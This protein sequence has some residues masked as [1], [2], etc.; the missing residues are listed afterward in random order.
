MIDEL[1]H[2]SFVTDLAA[3][4]AAH[5]EPQRREAARKF[6]LYLSG[7]V[8]SLNAAFGLCRAPGQR[9]ARASGKT[10]KRN[11]LIA[12]FAATRPSAWAAA[13]ELEQKLRRYRAAGW[14]QERTLTSNPH[15]PGTDHWHCWA[16][17][18]QH[19]RALS[20]KTIMRIVSRFA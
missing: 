9:D 5:P 19:D 1:A 18:A 12:T 8:D 10:V 17:L 16:I 6:E 4:L 11:E 13:K 2:L 3:F 15:R 14:E 20:A 7:R